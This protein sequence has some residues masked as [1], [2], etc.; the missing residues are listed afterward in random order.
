MSTRE[1]LATCLSPV[2]LL[3]SVMASGCSFWVAEPIWHVPCLS[4]SSSHYAWASDNVLLTRNLTP[5]SGHSEDTRRATGSQRQRK[6]I[7]PE[8][9]FLTQARWQGVGGLPQVTV[10]LQRAAHSC[11]ATMKLGRTAQLVKLP[12]S[13]TRTYFISVG[14]ITLKKGLLT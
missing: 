11:S 5:R 7:R 12:L 10:S 8:S 14:A 1:E 13:L 6:E 4:W 9:C 2:Q 3:T